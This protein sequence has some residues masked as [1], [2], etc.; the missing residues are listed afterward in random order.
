MK[1]KH[2][3]LLFKENR[4]LTLILSCLILT[5]QTLAG[6]EQNQE[7]YQ[8]K[9]YHVSNQ[10]QKEQLDSYLKNAYLPA[11]HRAGI[12]KVGVFYPAPSGDADAT[13]SNDSIVYVFIP[14]SSLSQF[15]ELEGLLAKDNKYKKDG[16][17]FIEAAFDK[18]P[19][20]R[21]ESILMHAFSGMPSMNVPVFETDRS[22]A[23]YELRSYEAAT[24]LLH[25]NKIKMFNEGE[26][27]IFEKLK[28]NAVFYA[29][30]IAGSKLPNLM[31]MTSFKNMESRDQHWKSFVEDQAWKDLS[32]DPQYKNNFLKADVYL[33]KAA[34]CS[35]I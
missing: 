5:F 19:Y 2:S 8:L 22:S 9:I 33:L 35:D 28:F 4:I 17:A 18:P 31:Y 3:A 34:S 7:Y 1:I 6:V 13:T 27:D 21:Y 20:A 15:A 30:V 16:N 12:N 14:F 11:L 32:S 25:L 26:I 24:E 23:I 29:R 10:D